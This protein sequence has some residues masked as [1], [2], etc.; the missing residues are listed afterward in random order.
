MCWLLFSICSNPALLQWHIKGPGHSAKSADGRL[1]LNMHTSL[2]QWSQEWADYA[3]VHGTDP[4][5]KSG[6]SV[7]K[8]IST[9]KK[10]VLNLLPKNLA[11]K[12]KATTTTMFKVPSSFHSVQA[13]PCIHA[14][15]ILY[16]CSCYFSCC[17]YT[18]MSW[19]S[20]AEPPQLSS[21]HLCV[22]VN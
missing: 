5:I 2:S 16:T 22:A 7:R 11:S 9:S 18:S 3:T 10:K 20:P 15:C 8:L 6:I 1:H 17:H 21:S 14:H 19:I 4:G 12:K 13:C